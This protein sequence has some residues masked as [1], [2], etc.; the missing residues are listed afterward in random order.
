MLTIKVDVVQKWL[1][2]WNINLSIT[3]SKSIHHLS[4]YKLLIISM[5][6]RI[7]NTPVIINSIIT[8][9]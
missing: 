9:Q 8:I 5:S 1:M 6:V 2:S 4:Q 3:A 7:T